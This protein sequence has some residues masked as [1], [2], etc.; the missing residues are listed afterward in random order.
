[1]ALV[2][3]Q[4]DDAGAVQ[5]GNAHRLTG[6]RGRLFAE[7]VELLDFVKPAQI[8]GAQFNELASPGCTR[9]PAC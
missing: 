8:G 1:M 7:P 9:P 2:A 5:H 4:V 3:R 6:Q